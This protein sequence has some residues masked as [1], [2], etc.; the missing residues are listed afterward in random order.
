MVVSTDWIPRLKISF[1][2]QANNKVTDDEVINMTEFIDVKSH[3]AK[4]KRLTT[5]VIKKIKLIDPLPFTPPH[6]EE[7]TEEEPSDVNNDEIDPKRLPE[8]PPK[9]KK[10]GLDGEIT[11]MTI[12]F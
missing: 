12:D 3:K 10:T 5:L 11:Q 8:L 7:Q 4:G 2:E 6:E 1:D 9:D